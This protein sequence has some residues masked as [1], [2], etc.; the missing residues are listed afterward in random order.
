[1]CVSMRAFALDRVWRSEVNF[2]ELFL[3]HPPFHAFPGFERRSPGLLSPGTLTSR[4][5]LLAPF[6]LGGQGLS[7]NPKL[8]DCLDWL[9]S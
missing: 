4:A 9:T 1:M 3:P 8:T 2:R 5:I 7:P 6:Y